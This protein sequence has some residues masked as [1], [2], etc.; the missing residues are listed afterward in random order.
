[1]RSY[2]YIAVLF[3]QVAFTYPHL[4]TDAP[5][6]SQ[7]GGAGWSGSTTCVI[8]GYCRPIN[9]TYSVCEPVPPTP[10][11]TYTPPVTETTSWSHSSVRPTWPSSVSCKYYV[12]DEHKRW[13]CA[14]NPSTT[15]TTNIVSTSSTITFTSVSCN[16]HIR[17]EN[18]K[19][20][21][22]APTPSITSQTDPGVA[23]VTTT[24]TITLNS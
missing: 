12:R 17:D 13:T 22:C 16:N 24:P 15:S 4:E 5:I 9:E 3:P 18:N 11:P 6:G 23:P 19:R 21:T 1:M 10:D 7:C 8:G 2:L 20:W 14:P